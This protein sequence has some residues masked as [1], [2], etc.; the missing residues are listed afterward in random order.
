MERQVTAKQSCQHPKLRLDHL[1]SLRSMARAHSQAH[2]GSNLSSGVCS[3]HSP[4]VDKTQAAGMCLRHMLQSWSL[5]SMRGP[6]G[7]R[8]M[9]CRVRACRP[10]RPPFPAGQHSVFLEAQLRQGMKR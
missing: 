5:Y 7:G 2:K 1:L 10:R 6:R 8:R 4:L 9:Q 3:Q